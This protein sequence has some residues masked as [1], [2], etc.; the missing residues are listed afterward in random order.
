MI[1]GEDQGGKEIQ[2][3]LPPEEQLRVESSFIIAIMTALD[4]VSR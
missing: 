1:C 4:F 3:V 2:I